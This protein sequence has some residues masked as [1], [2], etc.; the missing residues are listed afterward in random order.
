MDD[1]PPPSPWEDGGRP[2]RPLDETR[3]SL[4]K[5]SRAYLRTTAKQGVCIAVGGAPRPSGAPPTSYPPYQR[6]PTR[7]CGLTHPPISREMPV[8]FKNLPPSFYFP[9]VL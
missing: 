1:P 3:K 7:G 6:A 9:L 5:A 2:P 8:L 4:L